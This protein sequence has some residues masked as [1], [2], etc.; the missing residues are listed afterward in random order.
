MIELRELKS[1]DLFTM[2]SILNKIGID[3]LKEIITVD[4]IKEFSK[5]FNKEKPEEATEG[6]PEE[7]DDDIDITTVLG[8]NIVIEIGTLIVSNL[9]ACEM[10]VATLLSNLSG[11][12]KKEIQNINIVDYAQMIVDVFKKEEFKDFIKVVL[13]LFK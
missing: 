10:E 8:M 1:T 11:L 5:L 7:D 12:T 2:V 6:K 4:K 3:K 9:P 13:N